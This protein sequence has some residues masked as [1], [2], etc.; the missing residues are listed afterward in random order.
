MLLHDLLRAFGFL[1]LE[2]YTGCVRTW[3]TSCWG[4]CQ[5]RDGV[6]KTWLWTT[7]EMVFRSFVTHQLDNDFLGKL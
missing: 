7:K 4:L 2:G 6:Q 3:V 1:L 5:T